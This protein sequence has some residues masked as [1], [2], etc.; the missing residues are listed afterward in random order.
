MVSIILY[1]FVKKS[2][3]N[4]NMNFLK[5]LKYLTFDGVTLVIQVYSNYMY[6]WLVQTIWI[7]PNF[8]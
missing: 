4:K 6:F 2:A 5:F 8:N 1:V 7:P 3:K